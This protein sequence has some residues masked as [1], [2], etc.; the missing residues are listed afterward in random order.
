MRAIIAEPLRDFVTINKLPQT[1][2]FSIKV[3]HVPSICVMFYT[4]HVSSKMRYLGEDEKSA[5]QDPEPLERCVR[6]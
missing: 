1:S 3:C 6:M 2:V 5:A 4:S